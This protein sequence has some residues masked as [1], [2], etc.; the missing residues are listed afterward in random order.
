MTTE[1]S[2]ETVSVSDLHSMVMEHP[3]THLIDV[4]PPDHFSKVHLPGAQNACVFYMSFLADLTSI[5]TDKTAR[6]VIYGSS[7][8]SHDARTAVEKMYRAGYR[9][10]YALEGGIE[11]W[12]EAGNPCEGDAIDAMV[13]AQTT[14]SLSDGTYAINDEH[15]TVHWQGRNPTTSHFGTVSIS[16]GDIRVENGN[17]S[18]MIEVDMDTIRNINLEGDEL[19]SV[20]EAHLKSD[21]FFFTS[22]FPKA[23]LTLYESVPTEPRWQTAPNYHVK[24]KLNLRGVT[25]ALE[26]D[27]TVTQADGNQLLLEA[28]FDIDRTRWNV[29]YGSTRF[30]E[31]LG[32]HRVFDLISLQLRIIAN[33]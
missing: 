3:G 16:K 25:A 7:R 23:V 14:V 5:I 12:R 29:I 2:I 13:D 19:Q 17:I 24:G 4:L 18:G 33:R 30:F 1:N 26:F 9:E 15:S 11:A 27:M 8:R 10:V 32:M 6:V 31:H 21:D 22:V 20:L 28:H